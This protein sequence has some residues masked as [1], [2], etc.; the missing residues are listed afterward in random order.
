MLATSLKSCWS[1]AGSL[2]CVG[3]TAHPRLRPGHATVNVPRWRARFDGE[4]HGECDPGSP[5]SATRSAA[6]FADGRSS[7]A[8][9]CA[10]RSTAGR[11]STC[12]ADG[13]TPSADPAVGPG[14]DRVRLLVAPRGSRRS[15]CSCSSTRGAVDL[16]APV[17]RYWPE[18]AAAGKDELPVRYL[19]TH[20]AGLSAIVEAAARSAR[21]PTGTSW[22]TRSPSRN[23]GG[24]PAPGTATTAS[25][26]GTSSARSCAAPTAARSARVPRTT[27]SRLRSASTASSGSRSREEAAHRRHGRSRRWTSSRT[28]V[29]LALGTRR[30]RPEVVRQPARLQPRRA[31]ELARSS[32][33]PRSPPRT[34]T[35]TPGRSRASTRALAN[36]GRIDGIELLSPRH[37]RGVGARARRRAAIS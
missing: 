13:P 6:N 9:R 23:R 8:R 33:P 5:R 28:H 34:A 11:S 27:R 26:S 17:A 31:H 25:R 30:P 4:I 16:D 35:R 12:G 37:R 10:S 7:S 18:F 36:G 3:M 1:T 22:S 19:L 21:C 32:A 2:S 24:S 20:E 29:L 14:H 15:R